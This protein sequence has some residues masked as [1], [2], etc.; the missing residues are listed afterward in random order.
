M[1][2]GSKSNGMSHTDMNYEPKY[3][4]SGSDGVMK[5]SDSAGVQSGLS[6]QADSE[7]KN[8]EE[9]TYNGRPKGNTVSVEGYECG[10]L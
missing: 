2:Y 10:V 7:V 5:P 4:G 1:K 6:H 3:K 9:V 8:A